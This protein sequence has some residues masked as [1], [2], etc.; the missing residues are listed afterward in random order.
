MLMNLIQ[1]RVATTV[2][3]LSLLGLGLLP[4]MAATQVQ[5]QAA[6]QQAPEV[7]PA[8]P[9]GGIP[10]GLAPSLAPLVNG[11]LA[12]NSSVSIQIVEVDS[13][14]VVAQRTPEN[15]IAPASNMKIF[16]T[17][18]ALDLLEQPWEYVT[19]LQIRGEVDATGT[20]RGDVRIVG[21]GDPTIGGRFHDGNA[22][23]VIERWAR[24][25]QNS[26][27]KTI[28][29]DVVLEYGYFDTE[30]VHP[31]WPRDQLVNWYEAPIASLSMQ[32]G[33]VMVRVIAT[34]AGQMPRVE[35]EP[36]N[37]YTTLANR[38]VTG[39]GRGVY[40]TRFLGTNEIIV[41][42]NIPGNLAPT[43]V[44][45]TVENPLQYFANVVATTFQGGGIN[46]A[47]GVKLVKQDPRTDWRT[48]DEYRTPLSVVNI[49]INKQSQNQYAEQLLKTLGAEIRGNGSWQ[50]GSEAVE[51][52]LSGKLGVPPEQFDMVDGSGMSRDNRA[53]AKA[54]ITVLRHVWKGPY[55]REFLASLPYSGDPASRYGRRLRQEPYAGKVFAKTG[56]ISGVIGLS[57]YVRGNSGRIY[58]FSFLFNRY[59]TG[60]GAVYRLHDD[61]LKAV[62][63]NG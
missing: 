39:G 53:S 22:R 17:A 34:R 63:D 48:I 49:V 4:Q 8:A 36:P 47:G 51:A 15:T 61:M 33:T 10:P 16:T 14:Q 12:S 59:R 29:G 54:F 37:T 23:A 21:R 56:Y 50:G 9:A 24:A 62:I 25:L 19:P 52:W 2:I 46:I 45:V 44:F 55:R 31:T 6:P 57:G 27:V 5:P 40:I 1:N 35:F 38:A 60:T 3:F 13:G 11:Q 7:R 18:A 32:E 58:A 28:E 20:L 42:G 30:Y 43:E 41:R 26:G